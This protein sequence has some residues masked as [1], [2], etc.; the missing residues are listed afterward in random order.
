MAM[1][2]SIKEQTIFDHAGNKIITED[3]EIQIIAK[4][5]E[6]LIVVLGNVLSDEEC[7]Q[8][9]QKS[10]DRMQ[11]SKVAN[12]LEVDELR[13]SSSTFFEEGEN[14]FVA[15]IEK[16]VSQIMNIPVEHGEGLQILNYKIGQEYKA[17]FD[18][19]SSTSRAASN[20]RL[21][22]LV[23]YLNDVEQGGETYFPKLNF[24]VSPQK[25]M[26]VYFEYFYNDQKLND[27]TLHG[28]APVVI[29]DKW[30]ATQWMRRKK[31]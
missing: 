24:S 31:L 9:I 13:T 16:R 3:R 6:P 15:R 23:M 29:G 8:L 21:S 18:F 30:A 17:H 4:F 7:D 10:K 12:S 1:D 14:E 19:F 26:A 27:L 22:T 28:G 11:R 20:P 2:A 25:G 5:A